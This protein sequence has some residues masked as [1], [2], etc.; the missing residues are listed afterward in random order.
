MLCE[1][2][3]T[4]ARSILTLAS[5]MRKM[6]PSLTPTADRPMLEELWLAGSMPT[7]SSANFGTLTGSAE[8]IGSHTFSGKYDD[9]SVAMVPSTY[10]ACEHTWQS[11]LNWMTCLHLE[12]FLFPARYE[13][14]HRMAQLDQRLPRWETAKHVT[15]PG[16]CQRWAVRRPWHGAYR[17]G[18][19][20]AR[21]SSHTRL[22]F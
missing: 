6:V 17:S 15:A 14:H 13:P 3:R 19:L 21:H 16:C 7:Y 2:S 18:I 4:S 1:T 12:A 9:R 11:A 10:H 8:K 22:S 5:P 20:L